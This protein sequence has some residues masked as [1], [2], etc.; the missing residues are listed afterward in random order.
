LNYQSQKIESRLLD[1]QLGL[2]IAETEER[3]RLRNDGH[4]LWHH[5][6]S[7]S[8]LTPYSELRTILHEL[9][10]VAGDT[11]V[12]LGAGYGRMA[13]VIEAFFPEV[14]FLGYEISAER[15]RET[16]R[17]WQANGL[18]RSRILEVDLGARGWMPERARHYFVYDFGTRDAIEKSLE[19]LRKIAARGPIQVAARGRAVRDQVE[20]YHPWLCGVVAP[21]HFPHFS[22]YSSGLLQEV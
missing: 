15:V 21:R 8:F 12:D 16:E 1:Q 6:P 2:R 19:D 4:Q 17:C 3:V 20:R 13:F 18:K 9:A 22:I 10:P 7:D 11:V 5:L 14:S